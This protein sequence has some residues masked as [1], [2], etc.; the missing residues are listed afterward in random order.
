MSSDRALRFAYG[1][2]TD[3]LRLCRPGHDNV[4][5]ALEV[6]LRPPG[7]VPHALATFPPAP[8]SRLAAILADAHTQLMVAGYPDD[9]G[10]AALKDARDWARAISAPDSARN[11]IPSPGTTPAGL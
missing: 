3:E 5:I 2:V 6:V 1:I 4:M 11:P 10:L 8:V 7:V 9:A